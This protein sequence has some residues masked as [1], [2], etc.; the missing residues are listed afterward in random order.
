M[1][2]SDVPIEEA[3]MES[4]WN[5]CK[6]TLYAHPKVDRSQLV[7]YVS[8]IITLKY[9][10]ETA[11]QYHDEWMGEVDTFCAKYGID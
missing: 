2:Y 8:T 7:N 3:V 11:S 9:G 4:A 6:R 10:E 1:A 5:A